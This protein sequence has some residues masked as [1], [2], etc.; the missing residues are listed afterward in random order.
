MIDPGLVALLAA[1]PS[2]KGRGANLTRREWDV[3]ALVAEGRTDRGI[4][5]HLGVG[6]KTVETHI[7]SVFR[8]LGLGA[9]AHTNRR[10]SSVLWFLAE[11]GTAPRPHP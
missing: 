10:V 4:A 11:T 6:I 5:V 3:L 7:G 8:K 2:A 1:D 9:G